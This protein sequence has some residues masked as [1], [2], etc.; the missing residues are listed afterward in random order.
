MDDNNCIYVDFSCVA[1][2]S[3]SNVW[4]FRTDAPSLPKMDWQKKLMIEEWIDEGRIE[5]AGHLVG[6]S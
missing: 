4:G 6:K 5:D 2:D 3:Y 1:R